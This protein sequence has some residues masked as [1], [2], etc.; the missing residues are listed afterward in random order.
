MSFMN[1][2]ALTVQTIYLASKPTNLGLQLQDM[3]KV[4]IVVGAM[5]RDDGIER[6]IT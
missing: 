4:S 5:P 6:V 1:S 2:F 3:A